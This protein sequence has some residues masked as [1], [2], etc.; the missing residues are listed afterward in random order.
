MRGYKIALSPS[1][2]VGSKPKL[3]QEVSK[4]YRAEGYSKWW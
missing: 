1:E 4:E 3:R 2:W